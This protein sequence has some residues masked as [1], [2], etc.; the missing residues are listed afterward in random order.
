[1]SA[2]AMALV[3]WTL[4]RLG[5]LSLDMRA[6]AP[7][8]PLLMLLFMS[9]LIG[10]VISLIVARRILKPLKNLSDASQAVARGD[11]SI[12]LDED[13]HAA[14]LREL[15][16]NF[17]TM[18]AEL[19][20]V[21]T[22]RS[23][24]VTNVSHEFKTPLAAI[25]G[26]AALLQDSALTNSEREEYTRTIIE[27]THQLSLLT[28]N[29]LQ[30]SKLESSGAALETRV[31][32]LDEQIR[33]AILAL[34]GRWT[35]KGIE[36]EVDLP[37]VNHAGSQELLMRVWVNILDNAVK[38]SAEGGRIEVGLTE[39]GPVVVVTIRDYGKGMD[40]QE[41]RHIFDKFYRG[42]SSR[43]GDGNGLGLSL[44]KRIVDLSEG[45][46][47]VASALGAGST[48]TVTLPKPKATP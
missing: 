34:E 36:M 48:F 42:E 23:D 8:F 44:V 11:F 24:F 27:S 5:I 15:T 13:S 21:E 10:S 31:F 38:Y 32:R 45:S 35:Q 33:R 4:L 20:S 26:Y 1:S 22:L 12:R 6:P 40:A 29:I 28:G 9:G 43:K 14:E 41:Q 17:N 37:I 19:A 3:G 39:P 46:I 16:H 30:L 47:E 7:L 25:E 18:T 2:T